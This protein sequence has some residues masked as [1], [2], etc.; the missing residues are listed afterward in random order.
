MNYKS[1][2]RNIKNI[3]QELNVKTI[4]EGS[5]QK[6]ENRIRVNAQLINVAD[7]SHLWT[8]SYDRELNSVFKV[9]DEISQAIAETLK[10]KLT[11]DQGEKQKGDSV[12]VTPER[13]EAYDYYSKGMHFTKSKYILTF[14]ED[15]FKAGVEMFEKALQVDKDYAPAYLGLAWAY[16]HHYHVTGSQDDLEKAYQN[17]VKANELAPDSAMATA[18]KGYYQYEYDGEI[19]KAFQTIKKALEI[20]S[21]SASVN[22][23]TGA[24]LLYHGLYQPAIRYL[25]KSIEL[26]PY[27]FWTPYKLA[28]CYLNTGDFDQAALYFEKYFELAPVVLIFPGRYIALN[29]KME[30]FDVVEEL[31][32]RTEETHP[33]YDLLPY[34]KALL[35]AAKGEKEKA[36]A[37]YQNSEV[38]SLLGMPDEAIQHLEKEIRGTIR[39]PH[40]Q[41]KHL[42]NNPLFDNL[43][44]DSRFKKIVKREKELYEEDLKKYGDLE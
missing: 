12:G 33:D 13:L 16:E 4:L 28:I 21:N 34:C 8:D 23:I 37:L 17:C 22:F 32:A 43:R 5:I 41:Y 7:D 35:H 29:I 11:L 3:G 44:K 9:Q 19:D 27:Y 40:I 42:L 26:D 36:L 18:L 2:D 25:A 6:E 31:I 20:N 14:Q 24:C 30:K 38:Y 1:P 39:F 15:D 10:M